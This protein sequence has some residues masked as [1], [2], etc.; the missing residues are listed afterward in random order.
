LV[1]T[2]QSSTVHPDLTRSYT[3]D[4]MLYPF[5]R[6][7]GW[8]P[9]VTSASPFWMDSSTLPTSSASLGGISKY[10]LSSSLYSS[11]EAIRQTSM[12]TTK[13]LAH[14][15]HVPEGIPFYVLH[16]IYIYIHWAVKKDTSWWG[17]TEIKQ[18][19]H[20]HTVCPLSALHSLPSTW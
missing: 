18:S 11:L 3:S 19:L 14:R 16:S 7:V 9:L 1:T 17:V 20:V 12:K 4:T 10:G 5:T 2:S 13:S 15:C 8:S 6:Y